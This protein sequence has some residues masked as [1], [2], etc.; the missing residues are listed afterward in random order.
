MI[1]RSPGSGMRLVLFAVGAHGMLIQLVLLRELLAAFSGNELSAGLLLAFWIA[2]EALGGFC[3][4]RIR[5]DRAGAVLGY[6]AP[7]AAAVS[8]AAVA[9]VF[10][11]RSLAGVLPGESVGPLVLAAVAGSVVVLPAL[12]H[13]A[14]F[15]L[16]TAA[17][18]V[19]T[20]DRRAVGQ[21]YF[22]E[23]LGTALAA[24]AGWLFLF[25]RYGPVGLAA[26][27]GVLVAVVV[28]MQARGRRALPPIVAAVCLVPLVVFG[29]Q[30]E[31]WAWERSWP[32][33]RVTG[34]ADSHY[35]KVVKMEREGQRLVAYNGALVFSSPP[36]EPGFDEELG[37]V[38]LL[39]HAAPR[40]VLVIGSNLGLVEPILTQPVQE[41][42][43]AQIDRWLLRAEIEVAGAGLRQAL[44]D[45]RLRLE[46]GD[47]RQLL[48]N[49]ELR[50]TNF[51]VQYDCI[52]LAD[53]VPLS[54]GASRLFTV[55]FFR[56]CRSALAPG[57]VMALAGPGA[58]AGVLPGTRDMIAAR[59]ATLRQAF[60]FVELLLL[61]FPLW[62][63]GADRPETSAET[64]AARLEMRATETRL[65]SG[66]YIGALLDRFRQQEFRNSLAG[67]PGRVVSTDMR[68]VELFLG[69]ARENRTVS[70]GLA[71]VYSLAGR[72]RAGHLAA[73]AGL[74]LVLA[75][76]LGRRFGT[77]F[78]RPTGVGTSGFAGAGLTT[79]AL[80][81]YQVRF[82]SVYLGASLLLA[83]FMAG[84]VLGGFVG[85][86]A[87]DRPR[88]RG[89]LFLGAE[90]AI[91]AAGLALLTIMQQ[92][93]GVWFFVLLVA[94]GCAVGLEF[95]IAG[96]APGR[97]VGRRASVLLALDLAGGAAGA[98]LVTLVLVPVL[99]LAAAGLAIVVVK[100]ASLAC[101]VSAP[102]TDIEPQRHGGSGVA[103]T[104]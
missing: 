71:R 16:G 57:G 63:C 23:G 59:D 99:G 24:G 54:L 51:E 86:W 21:G 15:V 64:L 9:G 8:A 69:I 56:Q 101:Q 73:L 30:V 20:D 80:F 3:F 22:W 77:G 37:L 29:R 44:G 79:L 27:S 50:T 40:R 70:S 17:A 81:G 31:R 19:T 85:T 35:G 93:A 18:A 32:G 53:V 38:P 78:S 12:A 48:G 58:A 13:G 102:K 28:A 74:L 68:P 62:L 66:D 25:S 39:C 104:R 26:G 92:G 49:Y 41:V 94:A 72:L 2:A 1:I 43:F 65:L 34:S 55:E 82:G 95:P 83:G 36:T 10:V 75:L 60:P 46:V 103:R 100:L 52:I 90:A 5:A 87:A 14:L 7:A 4:G 67:A 47:P 96:A 84:T 33:Q 76:V 61:D 11:G 89:R 45:R 6:V 42:T 91:L 98:L 88:V 97:S